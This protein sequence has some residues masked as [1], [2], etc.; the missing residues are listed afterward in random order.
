MTPPA[1]ITGSQITAATVSGPRRDR[2]FDRLGGADPRLLV[3]LPAIGVGRATW[4][5]P[6]TSGPNIL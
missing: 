2:L 4:I 1:P 6:G 3:A 5:K